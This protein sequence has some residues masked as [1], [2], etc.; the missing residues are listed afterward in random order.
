MLSQETSALFLLAA[1]ALPLVSPDACTS[2]WCTPAPLRPTAAAGPLLRCRRRCCWCCWCCRRCCR[3]LLLPRGS[4]AARDSKRCAPLG[5]D[6]VLPVQAGASAPCAWRVSG[7][8]CSPLHTR[9]PAARGRDGQ[10]ADVN[11]GETKAALQ[12]SHLNESCTAGNAEI[13]SGYNGYGG[14]DRQKPL[15]VSV[16]LQQ[17]P[18]RICL[19]PGGGEEAWSFAASAALAI[20]LCLPAILGKHHPASCRAAPAW[21]RLGSCAGQRC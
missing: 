21:R 1:S 7:A 15:L 2:C 12:L 6:C 17:S 18:H 14:F 8:Y 11:E 9:P 13:G 10:V 20:L 4:A 3:C 16:C 19:S 5:R